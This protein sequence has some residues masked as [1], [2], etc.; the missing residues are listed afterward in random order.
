MHQEYQGIFAA[1]TTPFKEDRF[2]P[3][4]L[5][6]NLYKYNRHELSGYVI[7]G[8]TGEFVYLNDY[9][10]AAAVSLAKK[11]AFP[12]KKI[13]AGTARESTCHTVDFTNRIADAGAD[14]ALIMLPHYYKSLMTSEALKNHYLTLADSSRIPVIIYNIPRNTGVFP[15]SG[16]IIELCRHPNILGIKDSSGNL[17]F[18][19]EVRP[20]L[21]QDRVYLLGAGSLL[22]AGWLMGADGG[23]L[24]LA[25]VAPEL[26]LNLFS[27][28]RRQKWEDARELQ[29]SLVP[30]NQAVTVTYG[31]PAAKYAL[32]LLGFYGGPVRSPLQPLEQKGREDI[33]NHLSGLDLL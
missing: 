14:A 12:G 20:R 13:I 17:A 28:F 33:K 11:S 23:I 16:L 1:L 29:S 9:E 7:G 8:S 22:L 32:D 25:A 4:K 10:C 30:L 6:E 24:T 21:P 3:E 18:L 19:E 26:C 2:F 27:L 5:E 31:I 15:D